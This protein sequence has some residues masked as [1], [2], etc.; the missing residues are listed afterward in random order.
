MQIMELRLTYKTTDHYFGR[1]M[2]A[3]R[4]LYRLRGKISKKQIKI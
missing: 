2:Y 1:Y 4:V 3:F